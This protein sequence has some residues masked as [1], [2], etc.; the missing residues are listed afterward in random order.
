MKLYISKFKLN[1]LVRSKKYM[2]GY[3]N[4]LCNYHGV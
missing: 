1:L 3:I 4:P 2:F